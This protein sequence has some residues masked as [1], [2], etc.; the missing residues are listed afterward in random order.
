MSAPLG[1]IALERV[2]G[3]PEA[4]LADGLRLNVLAQSAG[5]VGRVLRSLCGGATWEGP[6]GV[7]FAARVGE[8]PMALERASERY[9]CCAGA[10]VDFSVRLREGQQSAARAAADHEEF[11][12]LAQRLTTAVL[13]DDGTDPPRLAE[14]RVRAAAASDLAVSA[15]RLW[16]STTEDVRDADAACARVLR[17]AAE[18]ALTDSTRY[19]VLRT[20]GSILDASATAVG[21]GTL[22]PGPWA[23]AFEGV[24]DALAVGALG[25]Q[26]GVKAGYGDGSKAEIAADTASL[27]GPAAFRLLR[28]SSSARLLDGTALGPVQRLTVGRSLTRGHRPAGVWSPTPRTPVSLPPGLSVRDAAVLRLKDQVNKRWLDDLRVATGNGPV[29]TAYLAGAWAARDGRQLAAATRR[30]GTAMDDE[31]RR[32]VLGPGSRP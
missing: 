18:D 8:V 25:I 13:D 20:T 9:A 4:M 29:A 23:P 3:D 10:I 11:S 1:F 31:K 2:P 21:A 6:A 14:L 12:L 22:V 17:A 28:V 32:P 15:R 30:A 24:S 7:A 27:A 5:A 19:A 16:S 26:V